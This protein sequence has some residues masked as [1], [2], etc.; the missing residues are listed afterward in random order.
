MTYD[1]DTTVQGIPCGVVVTHYLDVPGSFSRNAASDVDYYGF[2]ECDWHIV[3]RRGRKAEWLERKLSEED[4]RR[5]SKEVDRYM[6]Q[7]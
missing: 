5:I 4:E 7:R 3:D 1:F 2:T 6:E